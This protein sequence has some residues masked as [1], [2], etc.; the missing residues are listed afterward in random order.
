MCSIALKKPCKQK[1]ISIRTFMILNGYK[2][3]TLKK[4]I[5]CICIHLYRYYIITI[6]KNNIY[7]ST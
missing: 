4:P 1:N 6:I 3:T 7:I 2:P 5:Y